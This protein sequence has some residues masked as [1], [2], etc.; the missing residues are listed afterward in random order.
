MS[1]RLQSSFYTLTY[2]PLVVGISAAATS[3]IG[4]LG[5]SNNLNWKEIALM[6]VLGVTMGTYFAVTGNSIRYG[7]NYYWR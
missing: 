5:T 1:S 6:N 3:A 2:V 7:L 4:I